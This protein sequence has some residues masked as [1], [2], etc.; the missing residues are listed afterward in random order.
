MKTL[1]TII[2]ALLVV[3]TFGAAK[4]NTI[5]NNDDKT[6]LNYAVN[7]YIDA[8]SNG[9]VKELNTLVDENL[10]YSIERGDKKLVFNKTEYLE[11]L[12]ADEG[13]KQ[14]C[15]I[16]ST[17]NEPTPDVTILKIDMKYA[18]FTRTDYVTLNNTAKGWKVTTIYSAFK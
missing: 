4:A 16:T 10:K 15:L 5:Y 11:G 8:I 18:G 9:H 17:V 3:L 13:V 7:T 14:D 6:S 2:A 12:K 1:K